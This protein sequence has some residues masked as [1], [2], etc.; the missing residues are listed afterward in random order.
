MIARLL[1]LCFVFGGALA[2]AQSIPFGGIQHDS[3]LPVEITADTLSVDQT[4]GTAEFK[5]DV[6]AGQ[7][8]LKLAADRLVV[9][10]A[11]ATDEGGSGQ[12]RLMRA[13]GNVTMTNGVE[14]AESEEAIYTVVDGMMRMMG[15]VLLTQGENAIAGNILNINLDEGTAVFEGR[16]TSVFQS[17]DEQ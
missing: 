16:V 9:E 5:G 6:K 15:E 1:A 11:D 3:S 17:A 8:T 13:Y 14:A 2:Q 12:I 7:G 10:Y 4:A